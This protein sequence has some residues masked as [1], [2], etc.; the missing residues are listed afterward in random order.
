MKYVIYRPV[1]GAYDQH[2]GLRGDDQDVLLGRGWWFDP[3]NQDAHQVCDPGVIIQPWGCNEM[4][5]YGDGHFYLGLMQAADTQGRKLAI[6]ADSVG[7][8]DQ[9][10]GADGKIH[11][12]AWERRLASG[13]LTYGKT[14]GHFACL[15][16]YGAMGRGYTANEP[17]SAIWP[18]GHRD[19]AQFSWFGGRHLAIYRDVLPETAR[20]QILMGECGVSSASF[21]GAGGVD[22]VISDM[23]GYQTR[24]GG[25]LYVKACN[26]W[27]CGGAGGWEHSRMDTALPALLEVLSR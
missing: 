24:Y 15:H 18:D 25:D 8:P 23:R 9:F 2:P 3:R 14:N 7:N 16:E 11:S 1:S 17:G 19:D 21:A 12:P 4:N 22:G 5:V 27:T 13:C 20:M 26:Y 10:G 6:F